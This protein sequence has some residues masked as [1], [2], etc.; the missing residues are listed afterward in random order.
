MKSKI[1]VLNSLADERCF[2]ETGGSRNEGQRTGKPDGQFFGQ[3]GA[4]HLIGPGRGQIELGSYEE[5]GHNAIISP[6]NTPGKYTLGCMTL[7]PIHG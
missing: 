2:A 7:H 1:R 5:I 4:E 6:R 3:T